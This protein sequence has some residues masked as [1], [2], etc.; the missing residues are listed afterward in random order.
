MASAKL[1][2]KIDAI[3]VRQASP[4]SDQ[5][6]VR[7]GGESLRLTAIGGFEDFAIREHGLRQNDQLLPECE[8]VLDD[9]DPAWL[10]QQRRRAGA[11]FRAEAMRVVPLESHGVTV[12]GSSSLACQECLIRRVVQTPE[13]RGNRK[14]PRRGPPAVQ[15][16]VWPTPPFRREVN[17][18]SPN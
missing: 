14:P 1:G 4:G 3:A 5:T 10:A 8:V 11:S 15:D 16:M 2:G 17:G 6:E 13:R 7:P 12:I 18:S 9:Q